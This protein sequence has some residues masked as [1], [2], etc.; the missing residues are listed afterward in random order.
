MNY[1]FQLLPHANIRYQ[2][3]LEQ[4]GQAELSCMLSALGMEAQVRTERLG[5]APFLCFDAPELSEKELAVLSGH[6]SLIH[7]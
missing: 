3:S 6:L 5:G 7:I 4:L 1:C 2:E